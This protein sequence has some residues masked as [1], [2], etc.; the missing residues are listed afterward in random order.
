VLTELDSMNINAFTLFGSEE[1]FA[2][3]LANRMYINGRN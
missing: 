3:M 2:E 1:G